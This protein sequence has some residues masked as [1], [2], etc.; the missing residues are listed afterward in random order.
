MYRV[1][2]K[3]EESEVVM[4]Y[5]EEKSTFR[6]LG[7]QRLRNHLQKVRI[8]LWNWTYLFWEQYLVR[9]GQTQLES[10][11]R[12][13]QKKNLFKKIKKRQGRDALRQ[14]KR[15]FQK[16]KDFNIVICLE[17]QTGQGLRRYHWS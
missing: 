4:S 8:K 1:S 9:E 14:K 6:N 3:N 10:L 2:M 5:M 11:H 17:S 15:M 13:S 16:G 7:R 12:I